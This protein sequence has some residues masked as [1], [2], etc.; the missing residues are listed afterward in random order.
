MQCATLSASWRRR[1]TGILARSRAIDRPDRG[2]YSSVER[3]GGSKILVAKV[4]GR[5]CRRN[6]SPDVGM[7]LQEASRDDT[8]S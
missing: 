2:R 4:A 7:G 1:K 8:F 6:W 3:T 5:S